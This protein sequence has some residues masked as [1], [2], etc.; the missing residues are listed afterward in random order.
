MDGLE[1]PTV[2][3]VAN[4]IGAF[5]SVAFAIDAPG[6]VSHLALVGA[7]FGIARRPPLLMLPLG[8]PLIGPRLGRYFFSN[9]TRDGS[10]KF[11]GRSS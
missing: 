8:F 9:A 3:V 2:D 4:S 10:R 5:L 11:W 7:P 1:L 6:R